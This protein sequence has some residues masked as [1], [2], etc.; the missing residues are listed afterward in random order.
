MS[1]NLDAALLKKLATMTLRAR[2]A[3][4]G[5]LGGLHQ[6]P[7]KGS[8]LEFSRHRP[9]SYGDE[10]KHLDWKIYGRT[11]RFYVKQYQEDTNIRGYCL[12]DSSKSM[13][14]A[15]G[16]VSK[17]EY[18]SYLCA[19][20]TYL[21]I[22]QTDSVGL[23]TFGRKIDEYIPPRNFKGHLQFILQRLDELAPSGKT[24]LP[25]VF[26][27]AGKKIK[28]RGLL[29]VFSDL[30]EEPEKV[31]KSLK[32]FPYMKND[33]IVFHILDRE[34][35]DLSQKGAIQY[36]DMETG[37]KLQTRPEII[38]K[39]YRRRIDNYLDTLERG[40]R[41]HSI[42]Y[43]RIITDIPLDKAITRFMAKRKTI[44]S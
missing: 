27:D 30:L 44:L 11:D 3:A 17:L 10:L 39:E 29:I 1:I 35:V 21:M 4:E 2:Y 12:V 23:I 40:L 5:Y 36:R 20:V 34:E 13:G 33:V 41:A 42:D 16:Q 26:K 37:D 19:A 6:S 25:G 15:S 8:N 22:K 38:R 24:D 28:K 14:F 31:I 7:L 43:H 32:Y 9:Y 18:A